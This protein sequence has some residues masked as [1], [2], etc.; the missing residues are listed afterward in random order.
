MLN[1]LKS[2]RFAEFLQYKT[3]LQKLFVKYIWRRVDYCYKKEEQYFLINSYKSKE[4]LIVL[5][6]GYLMNI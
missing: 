2:T 4:D 3:F 6:S 1:L 5:H